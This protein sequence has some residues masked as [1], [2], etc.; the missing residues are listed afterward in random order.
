MPRTYKRKKK[1]ARSRKTVGRAKA[2]AE[3][4]D[5]DVA[6]ERF[7]QR[8]PTIAEYRAAIGL[9]RAPSPRDRRD[10]STES[11][12]RNPA[13]RQH[14]APS[15]A[16]S[17][18]SPTQL[19]MPLP[20]DSTTRDS[21]APPEASAHPIG[22]RTQG[23]TVAARRTQALTMRLP[24]TETKPQAV[25][26]QPPRSRWEMTFP[27]AMQ[28]AIVVGSAILGVLIAAFLTGSS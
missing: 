4:V 12:I 15:H 5:T 6:L 25:R 20:D 14:A 18:A 2:D 1:V 27:L 10:A 23:A 9:T 19:T 24:H 22:D 11:V 28:L 16:E 3:P 17:T 26:P 7:A 8:L 13:L 21:V